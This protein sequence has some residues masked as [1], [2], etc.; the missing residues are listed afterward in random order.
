[1]KFKLYA[2]I[3]LIVTLSYS[4]KKKKEIT[5][6]FPEI[7]EEAK[8]DE[9]VPAIIPH[10]YIETANAQEIIS[11]DDY[12]NGTVK[13]E[14]KGVKPDFATSTM[15]IKG[16][17]NS[18]WTKPKKP[19][20][21][22]LDQAASI[23]GLQAA[24]DWVLLANYQDYTFMTNAVAMKIGQQLGMPFTNNITPVDVTVN[25]VY[26]GNYNLTEQI[27]LK[28][29]RVDVGDGGVLLEL[30]I[31][32]DEDYQFRSA[33][34]TLPVMIKAPDIKSPE[35]FDAIKNSFEAF[36]AM[37]KASNFPNNN[38]GNLFDKQQLVNYLIVYN[39][40]GNF[41][42]KHPKSVYMYKSATGKYTMGPIWDFDWGFGLDEI[43]R[44]YFNEVT[45]PVLKPGDTNK[46]TVFF[47]RFLTD[48]EV[49]SLYKS[50]WANYK[51]N[52]FEDLLKYIENLAASI[53]DSQPKDL[54]KWKSTRYDF[55]TW[56]V[57]ATEL[58]KIKKDLKTYLRTRANYI[59][60]YVNGL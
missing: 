29:G 19:Y 59:T 34:Y 15:R 39:L 16:R 12:L 54:E 5:E 36:E 26:Q 2:L 11:K 20:R 33:A 47:A 57:N 48:P 28:A 10:I 55:A 3:V 8:L 22:K 9:T 4:C 37:V 25:G 30:D 40:T 31:N 23:F 45:A 56:S 18:T 46:G 52:K 17:G 58:P 44:Q 21:I 6:V 43:T 27:E 50:T 1:M 53:R 7:I 14:G 32:F 24:K 60:T 13:I 41:E 35:Q 38:Y 51:N 42:L 49:K